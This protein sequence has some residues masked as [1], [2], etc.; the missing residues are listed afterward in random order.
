MDTT[1]KAWKIVRKAEQMEYN[2]NHVSNASRARIVRMAEKYLVPLYPFA[3]SH[4]PKDGAMVD[5]FVFI[6]YEF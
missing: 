6:V 4:Y 5:K 2:D 1:E 3:G